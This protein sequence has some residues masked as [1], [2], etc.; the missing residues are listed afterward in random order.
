MKICAM[1]GLMAASNFFLAAASFSLGQLFDFAELL[2]SDYDL[3]CY[4][5]R[6][7][8]QIALIART[9]TYLSRLVKGDDVVGNTSITVH[10]GRVSRHSWYGKTYHL[11][12]FLKEA[13]NVIGEAWPSTTQLPTKAVW[14]DLMLDLMLQVILTSFMLFFGESL[15][16]PLM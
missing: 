12:T 3:I 11:R 6:D 14:Q 13:L 4:Q 7:T 15:V 5:S 16:H 8:H 2:F 1:I 10:A 9:D